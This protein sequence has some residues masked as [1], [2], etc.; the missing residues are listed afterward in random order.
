M[1]KILIATLIS[2]TSVFAI[3]VTNYINK[4]D[5]SKVVDKQV[6]T[7]CYDYNLKST[8]FAYYKLDGKMVHHKNDT[9][10]RPSFYAEKLIPSKYR[11]K[12]ADF[13]YTGKDRGHLDSHE[14]INYDKKLL[15]KTYSMVNIIPQYP[16]VNRNTW[17]KAEMSARDLA[18]K[19]GYLNVLDVVLY[20]NKTDYL[21]RI[22]VEEA[23]ESERKR[24]Y[25]KKKASSRDKAVKKWKKKWVTNY[26]KT[27]KSYEKKAKKLLK[28][29]IVVPSGYG[30]VLWNKE[31]NFKKCYYYKNEKN[32][33]TKG[34]KVKHHIISCKKLLNK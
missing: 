30:K 3:N 24:A 23:K 11:V 32:P 20:E 17:K 34:D 31:A 2:I 5:C 8:T 7:A 16:K 9:K 15:A 25:S 22:P 6:Y 21:K 18:V 13:T 27:K 29:K 1:K 12:P 33:K 28:K 10:K 26:S 4:N 14:N 19:Y